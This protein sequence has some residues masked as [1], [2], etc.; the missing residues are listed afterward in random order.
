MGSTAGSDR[1]LEV[2]F[3]R[4]DVA[5]R[6][7]GPPMVFLHAFPLDSRMWLPLAEELVRRGVVSYGLDCPGFGSTPPWPDVEPSIDAIADAAVEAMARL[8]VS[9]AHWVGC[10]MGGYVAL[11]I[12]ERHPDVVAGLGLVDTRSGADD[13]DRRRARQANAEET[14][15]LER[16]KDPRGWAE[17]LVGLEGGERAGVVDTVAALVA[18]A[19]P[20]AVAWGQRAMAARPDRTF[21]LRGLGRPAVVVW[22]EGDTV[23]GLDEA[24][25]MA[26]VLGVPVIRIARAGHLSP[27]EAPS[28]VA[29]ALIQI[30]AG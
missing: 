3:R 13:D 27:L 28:A 15:R 4:D 21:A 1:V 10:S 14:E 23:S 6:R 29:E 17:P 19:A 11:A 25:A 20:T 2:G 22:G 24:E 18:S 12:A 30:Y 7:E 26:E 8:G 5:D 16:L 9:S